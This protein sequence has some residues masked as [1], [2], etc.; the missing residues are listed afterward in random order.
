MQT[1][2]NGAVASADAAV[3]ESQP[4]CVLRIDVGLDTN[5]IREAVTLV[6]EKHKVC[7]RLLSFTYILNLCSAAAIYLALVSLI[8]S[9]H[10]L[11]TN[12]MTGGHSNIYF[13]YLEWPI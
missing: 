13:S 8:R 7:F 12:L 5:A 6:M 4:F 3:A 9:Y 1:A 11:S 10:S 2:L